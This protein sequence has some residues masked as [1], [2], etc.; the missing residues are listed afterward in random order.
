MITFGSL[1]AGI[2]G[3]DLALERSGMKCH[4]Q[5]EIDGKCKDVLASHWPQVERHTDVKECGRHNLQPVD[6]VCGGFPCQDV[7]VAGRR[8]GLAGER[9]GLWWEFHRIIE[10]L[11]PRW[12]II[13][14]VNVPG[15]LSSNE[16]C[17][18]G[19]FLGALAELGYG[20]AYRVLDAQYFGVA[21]RRRRVF[22]VG[23][24]GDARRAAEVLFEPESCERDTAPSR[25]KR[26]GVTRS[27]ADIAGENSKCMTPWDAESKRI[28][29]GGTM[30]TLAGSD[31][32]GGQRMPYV[33]FGGN[34]TSGPIDVG[35]AVSSND[36]YDF[37]TET[38]V[39]AMHESGQ[40]WWN[41][42]NLSGTIRAEGENRPSRPSNVVAIDVRNSRQQPDGVSGTLQSKKTGGYSLNYQ[43]PVCQTLSARM[44]RYSSPDPATGKGSPVVMIPRHENK[45]GELTA[46]NVAGTVRSAA[47][48][49]Y[50]GVGVRRLMPIECER[51]QGFPDGW[52]EGQSDSQRYKQLGNAVA[53][54]VVEWIGRRLVGVAVKCPIDLDEVG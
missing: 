43:N 41:E 23:C 19:S 50:Q 22:I 26:E 54:P 17:D 1:F 14:N 3:F 42:G 6:L 11:R 38:F 36:R 52:T 12:C 49:N 4:W 47:S 28:H 29:A 48:H 45:Q 37:D 34:N 9:S 25:E 51:L 13:E 18:F 10:E 7:S 44:G 27:A 32:G 16:G 31:G 15:L 24:L 39:A 2:G 30:A 20:W 40:G 8:A 33:S 46:S 53:V 5:V 35:A 21:Q